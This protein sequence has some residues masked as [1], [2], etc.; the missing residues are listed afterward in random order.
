M[1][2]AP[3]IGRGLTK[4]AGVQRNAII[5]CWVRLRKQRQGVAGEVRSLCE[6]LHRQG[7]HTTPT[8]HSAQDSFTSEVLSRYGS[9]APCC[10]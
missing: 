5:S 8:I 9:S 10:H 2:Q 1:L 6:S 3:G 7:L 4:E